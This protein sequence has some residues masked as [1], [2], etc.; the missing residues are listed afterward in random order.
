[1]KKLKVKVVGCGGVGLCVLN[2]LPRYLS[3]LKD[4]EVELS[5]IDGDSFEENNRS[6]QGFSRRGNKAEVTAE[7]LRQEFTN[8]YCWTTAEYLTEENVFML[9]RDGDVVFSCVDNHATRKLLSERCEQ[10]EN[11]VLISGGNEY[12][13]GNIQVHIR[14]NG[15]NVTQPIANKYHPEIVNPQDRNPGDTTR[16][17]GCDAQRESQP[18]LLITNNSVAA[19]MLNA[20]YAWLQGSFEGQN[21][22]DE[23]YTDIKLNRCSP[24]QRL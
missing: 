11:V 20:F 8:L 5:L 23:V 16:Q 15:Q 13:D 18:Q 17:G 3:Y 24:R 12:E 21:K 2:V 22:Y 10:L 9:I 19:L 7:Q 6:R 1:M 4:H 14:K